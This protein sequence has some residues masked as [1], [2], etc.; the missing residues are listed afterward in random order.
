MHALLYVSDIIIINNY[1][2]IFDIAPFPPKCS[3]ALLYEPTSSHISET[4]SRDF[5]QPGEAELTEKVTF[6][7]V[8]V[9]R[10]K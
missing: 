1:Q 7:T 9:Q 4:P 10:E 2:L 5:S 3:K 6:L 8:L